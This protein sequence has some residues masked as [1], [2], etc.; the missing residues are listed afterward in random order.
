MRNPTSERVLDGRYANEEGICVHDERV[1]QNRDA[2]M[3]KIQ[4]GCAVDE[5]CVGKMR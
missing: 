4:E 1:C 5:E 3:K 2:L